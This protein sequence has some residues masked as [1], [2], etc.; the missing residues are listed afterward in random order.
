MQT[1]IVDKELN[2]LKD[3]YDKALHQ[4]SRLSLSLIIKMR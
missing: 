2:K 1:Q 4:I 3:D